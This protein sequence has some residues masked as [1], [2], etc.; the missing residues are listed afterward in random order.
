VICFFFNKKDS[1]FRI[2]FSNWLCFII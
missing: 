1:Y 2:D